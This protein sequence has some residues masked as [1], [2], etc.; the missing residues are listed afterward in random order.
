MFTILHCLFTNKVAT[1]SARHNRPRCIQTMS[2]TGPWH[3]IIICRVCI[4]LTIMIIMSYQCWTRLQQELKPCE[5]TQHTLAHTY[6]LTSTVF[7]LEEFFYFN[8][9]TFSSNIW[10]WET[11]VCN[12]WKIDIIH[13]QLLK[14]I[15]LIYNEHDTK[16]TD[17]L[18]VT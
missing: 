3:A 5:G 4:R 14:T 18:W 9:K 17:W 2:I 7:L 11:V 10:L 8:S 15:K 1:A 12:K 6:T 16:S 13:L